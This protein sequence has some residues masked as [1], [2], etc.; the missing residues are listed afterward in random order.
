MT[1]PAPSSAVKVPVQPNVFVGRQPILDRDRHVFGYE[2]LFRSNLK[3][4]FFAA[5][6][7][8]RASSATIHNSLNVMG[9]SAI[10]NGHRAFVNITRQLLVNE[11]Y[12]VMP[13]AE[14]VIELLETVEPDAEVV[15]A[16]RKL[17]DAGYL[18]A[19]DDFVFRP[20]YEPLLEI[21]DFVKIEFLGRSAEERAATVEQFAQ[22]NTCLIAEKVETNEDFEQGLNLGYSYFQ[23]YFFCKPEIVA[24][25]DVPA[26]KRNY[27]R[28]LHE[29][30][31]PVLDFALLEQVVKEEPS[32]SVKL[33]RY[34]NSAMFGLRT[35]VDSIRQALALMG[36][37]QLKQWAS[38]V[39]LTSLGEDKPSEL[40]TLCLVRARCCEVLCP[41]MDLKGRELDLFLLGLLSAV[42]ALLDR[43]LNEVL[44]EMPVAHDVK[45]AL[46]G[47]TTLLGSVYGLV[48]ACE[49]GN[50]RLITALSSKLGISEEKVGRIYCES[51]LW[52]DAIL[53]AR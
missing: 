1:S 32:L 48:I 30:T 24:G 42:D 20:G 39:A 29:T 6:D 18:L 47:S 26:F 16:C 10:S 8:D 53:H 7:G 36:E 9:L 52:A 44:S 28:F 4:N 15:A 5:R 21:A 50:R 23:G 46:L 14:A 49:R 43:P 38:L 41:L 33:L 17:K 19:L 13:P 35:K 3:D 22:R 27:L 34:L 51:M 12:M 11:L 25:R 2:L 37:K 31:K 40:V 45:A